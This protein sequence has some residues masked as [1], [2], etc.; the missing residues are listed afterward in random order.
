[1]ARGALGARLSESHWNHSA[2]TW[3]CAFA[4]PWPS[5]QRGSTSTES[6]QNPPIVLF[7][8]NVSFVCV[9]LAMYVFVDGGPHNLGLLCDVLHWAF[10]V[11]FVLMFF[12]KRIQRVAIVALL[13]LTCLFYGGFW[14]GHFVNPYHELYP[15]NPEHYEESLLAT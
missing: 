7:D 3:L 4:G 14:W 5:I 12:A 13:G 9:H 10:R 6:A 1:L 2:R 15:R 8:S 11:Y